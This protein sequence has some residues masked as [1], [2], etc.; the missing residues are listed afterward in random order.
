MTIC[1][2]KAAGIKVVKS[3]GIE[4]DAFVRG[5]AK[6]VVREVDGPTDTGDP[7]EFSGTA[8]PVHSREDLGVAELV[9]EGTRECPDA[10]DADLWPCRGH[11]VLCTL[12]AA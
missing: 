7:R 6:K 3:G 1:C 4:G 10:G 12:S 8:T 2:R 11:K 9:E 5:G